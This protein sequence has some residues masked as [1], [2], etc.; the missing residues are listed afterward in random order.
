ME[1]DDQQILRV[2]KEWHRLTAQGELDAVLGLMTEDAVSLTCGSPPMTKMEFAT[3]FRTWAG[4]ARTESKYEIK[5]M[6]ASEDVAYVW[7]Y[8]SIVMTA[9][10][11]GNS[12]KR[13]GH[14]LSVFRKLPSG[15]WPLARDANLMPAGK[16]G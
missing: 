12:T 16:Q 1:T 3:G 9:K 8:I 13:E 7:S 6:R 10:D 14:A 11:T 4:R 5:D 15:K 2:I